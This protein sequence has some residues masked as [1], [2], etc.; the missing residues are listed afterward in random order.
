MVNTPGQYG[1]TLLGHLTELW[2]S[3]PPWKTAHGSLKE[4]TA[5][6]KYGT[7]RTVFVDLLLSSSPFPL[8]SVAQLSLW[9]A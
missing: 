7:D 8:S 4:T 1:W 6:Y 3:L 2:R 9:S 5:E